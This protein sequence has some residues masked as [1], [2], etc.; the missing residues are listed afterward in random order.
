[1]FPIYFNV[2]PSILQQL[3]QT[4]G[5]YQKCRILVKTLDSEKLKGEVNVRYLQKYE[6][7]AILR[8]F[9]R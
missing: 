8:N 1:M 4:N 5:I 6:K 3:V 2:K 9:P 7:C